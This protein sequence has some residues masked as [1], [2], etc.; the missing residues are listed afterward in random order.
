LGGRVALVT[1]GSQGLG[2]ALD[3]EL[4]AQG[5]TVA[6]TYHK[7]RDAALSTVAACRSLRGKAH[8]FR[9]DAVD[10]A[11]TEAL[12]SRLRRRFRRLDIVVCNVGG[13]SPD[14]GPIWSLTPE[15]WDR[16]MTYNLRTAFNAV[17][18]TCPLLI[19]KSHGT[20]LLIGSIN[21]LRGR[22]GHPAY[23][24]AK[25]GLIGFTKTLANELGAHGI[26]VN[27]LANGYIDNERS[28]KNVKEL[29]KRQILNSCAL[30]HLVA[31][32][33]VATFA[34]FLCSDAARYVTGT[35]LK[36]DSGEYI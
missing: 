34:A 28:R 4:A 32:E 29:A 33:D 31:A 22:E 10:F 23:S 3:A 17:R 8:A 19:A 6:F 9:T 12:V 30:R 7:D 5:A 15:A 18:A 26:N 1:G 25:A 21:G 11:A 24:T 14:E 36:M 2:R 16:A 20:I 13:A 27:L 35:I